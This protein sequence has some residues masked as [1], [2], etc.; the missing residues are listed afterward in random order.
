MVAFVGGVA[1][2]FVAADEQARRISVC[3]W[4]IAAHGVKV[5]IEACNSKTIFMQD[6][7]QGPK[8]LIQLTSGSASMCVS[9]YIYIYIHLYDICDALGRI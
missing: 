6:F 9:G 5:T 3:L 4:N 7:R 1:V 8:S 2:V